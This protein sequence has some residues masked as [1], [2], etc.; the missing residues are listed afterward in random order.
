MK[1]KEK[2]ISRFVAE[3]SDSA[4]AYYN[5]DLSTIEHNIVKYAISKIKINDAQIPEYS[6]SEKEFARV[7]EI[8]GDDYHEQIEKITD[9]LSTKR[10]RISS[11]DKTGWFP[12][13]LSIGYHNEVVHI[14]FNTV[15]KDLVLKL[16][17]NLSDYPFLA[18]P[19]LK[20]TYS[21]SLYE[22]LVQ[23]QKLGY[24]RI[25][26]EDLR[27][28]LGLTNKYPEYSNIKQRVINHAQKELREKTSLSFE[29]K[30]VKEAKKVI[31]LD[32]Y[33]TNKS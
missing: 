1:E 10:V 7:T 32:F 21:L 3:Q 19:P 28:I 23:Y 12:W 11:K 6:F 4:E 13:F 17:E 2:E 18:T 22:L 29:Y 24:Q 5:T 30:E 26:L 31:A 16:K 14:S 8:T 9:Q 20:S 15:L 33:I 25:S 27:A